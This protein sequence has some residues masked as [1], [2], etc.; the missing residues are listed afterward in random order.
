MYTMWPFT[1]PP[2]PL[3]YVYW[4]GV[5]EGMLTLALV[6]VLIYFFVKKDEHK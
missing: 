3:D 1:V 6:C 5:I 4:K 2:P